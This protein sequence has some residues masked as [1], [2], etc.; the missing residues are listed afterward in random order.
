MRYFIFG[1]LSTLTLLIGT[2]KIIL[3]H[4]GN[5]PIKV[6]RENEKS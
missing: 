6:N 1:F 2:D 4:D 5:L 3:K